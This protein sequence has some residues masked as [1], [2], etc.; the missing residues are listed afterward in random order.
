MVYELHI[1]SMFPSLLATLF[2]VY[3]CSSFFFI[4]PPF[5]PHT[6]HNSLLRSNERAGWYSCGRITFISVT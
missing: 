5:D 6:A 2:I 4:A 3:T 1:Q